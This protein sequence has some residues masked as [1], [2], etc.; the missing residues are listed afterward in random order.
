MPPA[1][2][3]SQTGATVFELR[4]TGPR[5]TVPFSASGS[6]GLSYSYDCSS[7]RGT[8]P[9]FSLHV[10]GAAIYIAPIDREETRASDTI[11]IHQSGLFYLQIDTPCSWHV[12]AFNQT[13][14][15]NVGAVFPRRHR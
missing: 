6:W 12:K 1:P 15:S 4:G 9:A 13:P 2:N 14:D 11:Y 8:Q 3:Y 5:T 7:Q 10:G